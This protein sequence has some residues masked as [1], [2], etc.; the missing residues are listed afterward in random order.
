MA[1]GY[2]SY[3]G[4]QP[5]GLRLLIVLLVLILVVACGFLFAQRY[6]VYTE[7]GGM[8]LDLPFM[9]LDLPTPPPPAEPDPPPQAEPEL[10]DV[11]LVIDEPEPPPEEPPEPVDVYGERRLLELPA[12]PADAAA[13]QGMLSAAGANGFLF[14]VRDDTGLV[15][16]T[17]TAAWPKAVAKDA[18]DAGTLS[19]LCAGG[20]AVAA[21]RFNCLHDSYYAFDNM[22]DAAICQKNGYVW[23]D[24][25]SYH[26]IDPEK[27]LTRSYI[28]SLAVECA[29]LGFDELV[30]EELCYPTLGKL[31]K[32]DYSGNTMGKAEA[33]ALL[34]TQLR[35][36]LEPYG[37]RLSLLLPEAL[38]QSGGDAESGQDLAV[39]L[40][41]VDAVYVETADPAGV[42]ALLTAAA[43]E[44]SVPEL[45]PMLAAAG[46][47]NWCVA[48]G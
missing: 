25:K 39:L 42:Q 26:W 48:G 6:I 29:Q 16:Y 41:L 13:L 32:I 40:P 8:Y 4:R 15:K 44:G 9:R 1:K 14:Q 31:Q 17:S 35:E 5:A 27:E 37:T 34:L 36:A 10:P 23:Y 19:A 22:K 11:E 43:G 33:L 12:L 46:E 7:D 28:I 21:A 20:D 45:V 38:L 3:R 18:A 47:G 30:L 2:Q 24:S